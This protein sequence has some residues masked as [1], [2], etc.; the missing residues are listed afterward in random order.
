MV[1]PEIFSS[2]LLFDF[3]SAVNRHVPRWIVAGKVAQ[4]QRNM[5]GENLKV[6]RPFERNQPL[7]SNRASLLIRF[8][9]KNFTLYAKQVIVVIQDAHA[10]GD[11][12]PQQER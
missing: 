4:N 12:R 7:A 3:L 1:V 8:L 6:V 9:L 10:R 2:E 11:R 5:L